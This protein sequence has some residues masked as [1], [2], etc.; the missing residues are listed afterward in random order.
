MKAIIVAIFFI[1]LL[2]QSTQSENLFSYNSD[3]LTIVGLGRIQ[4]YNYVKSQNTF[5][6]SS[7]N[8]QIYKWNMQSGDHVKIFGN[9][10]SKIASFAISP[11]SSKLAVSTFD[12]NIR[13][14]DLINNIEIL[15]IPI[16][17]A[18]TFNIDFNYN[19]SMIAYSIDDRVNFKTITYNEDID[20]LTG[21]IANI[22]G[23][24]FSRSHN[25]ILVSSMNAGVVEVK[26]ATKNSYMIW[27]TKKL[28][29]EPSG[30]LITKF[31]DQGNLFGICY[32]DRLDIFSSDSI[33]LINS[34]KFSNY[35][36]YDFLINE[37]K[38]IIVLTS[39]G[40]SLVKIYDITSGT[41]VKSISKMYF[42]NIICFDDSTNSIVLLSSFHN[43]KKFD[44]NT[45][46]ENGS[47]TGHSMGMQ[48][49]EFVEGTNK[50]I[51]DLNN[52]ISIIDFKKG[53]MINQL[54][55]TIKY[56]SYS[57][58]SPD[59][60][61]FAFSENSNVH[62]FSADSMR[63]IQTY[64]FHSS[65]VFSD[66]VTS[67][68]FSPDNQTLAVSAQDIYIIDLSNFLIK[69]KIVTG[70]VDLASLSY[71]PDSKY[72]AGVNYRNVSVWNVETEYNILFEPT[73]YLLDYFMSS[74]FT[75]DGRYI[76]A[77]NRIGPV[78]FLDPMSLTVVDT[79]DYNKVNIL[80][81]SI[82]NDSRLIA[83]STYN[84]EMG[85]IDL[86]NRKFIKI[87]NTYQFGN[88]YSVRFNSDASKLAC[89]HDD[90]VVYIYNLDYYLSIDDQ[91]SHN[92]NF[93]ISPNPVTNFLQ[94]NSLQLG[95][96]E[97]FSA[98]GTKVIETD[99]QERIDVSGLSP[100]MYFVKIGDKVSKFIKII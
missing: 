89:N 51:T 26:I 73:E 29:A 93:N 7:A 14:F 91:V 40:D 5:Y 28:F 15:S 30:K 32:S 90:G 35:N 68:S 22:S 21:F 41:E 96:I 23:L 74:A 16:S 27:T 49:V 78:F 80:S 46:T 54:P 24:G 52:Q 92:A 4:M 57:G 79:M 17:K 75:P 99:W 82:S 94:I 20:P 67:F 65:S 25:T 6:T 37:K 56:P 11:D 10:K 43:I 95:R 81:M 1:F 47:F 72:L 60:K 98:I 71:S 48:I 59:N 76:I 61:F 100:G 34:I 70:M 31:S 36:P 63:F 38:G 50:I 9:L 86:K 42:K 44:L 53:R 84:G 18:A 69:K 83:L 19:S 13:I 33:M 58:F 3:S 85:I 87:I 8:G 2:V 45:F 66:Y 77:A 97:I 55:E 12:S 62:L 88:I 39:P 64:N